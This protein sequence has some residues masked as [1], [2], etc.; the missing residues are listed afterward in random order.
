MVTIKATNQGD[1]V[2]T[3]VDA[4]GSVRDTATEVLAIVNRCRGILSMAMGIDREEA[5]GMLIGMLLEVD[6]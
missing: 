4:K 2:K 6:E 3:S 5:T 1:S